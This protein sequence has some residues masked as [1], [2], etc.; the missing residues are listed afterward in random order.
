MNTFIQ[1]NNGWNN[2]INL[3]NINKIFVVGT[4]VFSLLVMSIIV[5]S[6]FKKHKNL[7]HVKF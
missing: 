3:V 5:I 1:K 4:Q 6:Y 7:A 2:I